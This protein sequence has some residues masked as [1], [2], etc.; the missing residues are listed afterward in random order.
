MRWRLPAYST[1]VGAWQMLLVEIDEKVRVKYDHISSFD[2]KSAALS[3]LDLT[4]GGLAEDVLASLAG[5]GGLRVAEDGGCLVASSALDV[6]EVGVWGGDEPL[7]LVLLL[8]RLV[9]GV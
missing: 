4:A 8:L 2:L 7:E 1:F 3:E 6:H 5:D 9:G